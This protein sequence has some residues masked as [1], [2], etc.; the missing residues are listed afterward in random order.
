MYPKDKIQLA[1]KFVRRSLRK[2]VDPNILKYVKDNARDDVIRVECQIRGF[3]SIND[4]EEYKTHTFFVDWVN[5]V[6]QYIIAKREKTDRFLK[7][8]GEIMEAN[9]K[10]FIDFIR[11]ENER[12]RLWQTI[13]PKPPD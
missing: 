5:S 8:K 13:K 6:L 9:G 7:N 3:D 12:S 1:N 4:P 10:P 11:K 2:K